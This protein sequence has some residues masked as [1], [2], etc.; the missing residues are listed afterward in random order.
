MKPVLLIDG[1]NLASRCRYTM[2]DLTD[3]VGNK[4]GVIY[5]VLNSLQTCIKTYSP[6]RIIVAWDYGRAKWRQTMY[7]AYKASRTVSNDPN[8]QWEY[9]QYLRQ[10]DILQELLSLHPVTNVRVEGVEADDLIAYIILFDTSLINCDR[11]ILS[12]DEDFTQ[13]LSSTTRIYS[14]AQESMIDVGSLY[15]DEGV[16]PQEFLIMKCFIGDGSDEIVGYPNIG[17]VTAK[18]IIKAVGGNFPEHPQTYGTPQAFAY[19]A[20]KNRTSVITPENIKEFYRNYMLMSLIYGANMLKQQ[21]FGEV[22]DPI[23]ARPRKFQAELLR[24]TL[25]SC[26]MR[27][28]VGRFLEYCR[29]WES[30]PTSGLI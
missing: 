5:G 15:R 27:K 16:S 1:N 2:Q 23:L 21:A 3:S 6:E 26:D 12:S 7:P 20:S 11:I 30:V 28:F 8:D 24:N 29:Y 4:T 22:V 13:L 10:I 18:K 25:M 19:Y 9:S 17:R 14:P